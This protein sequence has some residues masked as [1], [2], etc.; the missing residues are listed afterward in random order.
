MRTKDFAPRATMPLHIAKYNLT[1]LQDSPAYDVAMR[2]PMLGWSAVL[3]LVSVMDLEQYMR[4]A[5]PALPRAIYA[6]NIAM[7]L[8]L[9]VYLVTL[10]AIVAVRTPPIGKALGAEPRVSALLG[11]FLITAVVLFPRR[12]LSPAAGC[13]STLLVLIGDSIATV[14][15]IQLRGSFSIMAEARQLATSGPYRFARHPLYLAE[16]VA[17]IGSVMQFLSI[18]T[19][20]LVVVQIACQVRRMKNEEIVLMEVF[21]EYSSYKAKTARIV[22]GLY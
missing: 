13:I 21:P 4:A 16:E 3:A 2:L 14:V 11:S 9:I 20:M 19:A 18:W 17:T 15:L 12:D 1:K 10:A 6:E 5:D 22:P 7:R 8:S